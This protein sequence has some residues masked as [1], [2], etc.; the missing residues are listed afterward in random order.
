MRKY[1]IT[2]AL[3]VLA[4]SLRAQ[5][6]SHPP[7]VPASV[8]PIGPMMWGAAGDYSELGLS[9]SNGSLVNIFRAYGFNTAYWPNA[10]TFG[11]NS[12]YGSSYK[13]SDFTGKN[14]NL[15]MLNFLDPWDQ[16]FCGNVVQNDPNAP[17][18]P[19]ALQD[20][21]AGCFVCGDHGV[22]I[23]N[24]LASEW[25]NDP[26]GVM[27]ITDLNKLAFDA[28]RVEFRNGVA[29]DVNHKWRK[30]FTNQATASTMEYLIGQTSPA[31]PAATEVLC[32]D[33][34][35]LSPY[36]AYSSYTVAQDGTIT[37]NPGN[38]LTIDFIYRLQPYAGNSS[39]PV[40]RLTVSLQD[41]QGHILASKPDYGGETAERTHTLS[42]GEFQAYVLH[43][44]TTEHKKIVNFPGWVPQGFGQLPPPKQNYAVLR[45]TPDLDLD[46]AHYSIEPTHLVCTLSTVTQAENPNAA[47]PIFVRGFRFRSKFADKTLTR[48]NDAALNHDFDVERNSVSASDWSK[49]FGE[50]SW[51]EPRQQ[52]FR[53]MAYIDDLFNKR[54]GKHIKPFQINDPPKWRSIYVDQ[55]DNVPDENWEAGFSWQFLAWD[56]DLKG[57]LKSGSYGSTQ[58]DAHVPYPADI[59]PANEFF[60]TVHTVQGSGTPRS[61]CTF[62]TSIADPNYDPMNPTAPGIMRTDMDEGIG[63]HA[64]YAEYSSAIWDRLH[65]PIPNTSSS[66]TIASAWE[67]PN[68]A[69]M[70]SGD[71]GL[72]AA[73]YA[74]IRP[75]AA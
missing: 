45:I 7:R 23:R 47:P 50:A 1:T 73:T 41:G 75:Q 14:V 31:L 40:Y 48:G 11:P 46:P 55:T 25:G 70:P 72:E 8:F 35:N 19:N 42:Y 69:A 12:P 28:E 43:P 37:D 58:L 4:F 49:M 22:E 52:T 51:P 24:F 26:S 56:N 29:D 33:E 66:S 10:A 64:S 63:Y 27:N 32:Y 54:T 21:Y 15:L 17:A 44:P 39:D 71:V 38:G 6:A 2:L 16:L 18:D 59:L 9:S 13:G 20:Y 5:T 30:L 74:L 65:L 68:N 36:T 60:G 61:Y 62:N 3:L 57:G 53:V 67:P 34:T